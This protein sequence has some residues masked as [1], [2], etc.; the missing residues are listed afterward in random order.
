MSHSHGWQQDWKAVCTTDSVYQPLPSHLFVPCP[1]VV[2]VSRLL[3]VFWE[4]LVRF[5]FCSITDWI[6]KHDVHTKL[7]SP[8][9]LAT[10]KVFVGR[11]GNANLR[12]VIP[13]VT[14]DNASCF[15]ASWLSI[16]AIT[17]NFLYINAQCNFRK[18]W[19]SLWLST[20]H[21]FETTRKGGRRR[22]HET[23]WIFEQTPPPHFCLKVVCK[24]GG[25]FLGAYGNTHY[26]HQ[27]YLQV[28]T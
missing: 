17:A 23:N 18:P 13:P 12:G 4:C 5:W 26:N 16:N 24:M 20:S 1:A 10:A 22:M 8:R 28:M 14:T 7:L 21:V 15:G 11:T 6:C 27:D 19:Q 9:F 2:D 25:V 3:S